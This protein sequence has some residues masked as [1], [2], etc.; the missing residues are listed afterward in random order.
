[1][2]RRTAIT[3]F[4][5]HD[6]RDDA[7]AKHTDKQPE[8]A[9]TARGMLQH[10]SMTKVQTDLGVGDASNWTWIGRLPVGVVPRSTWKAEA[11]TEGRDRT[12]D[13]LGVAQGMGEWQIALRET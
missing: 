11:T 12:F 10:R 6:I 3:F 7:R 5:P 2:I 1:M 4:R 9:L 13:V 8:E